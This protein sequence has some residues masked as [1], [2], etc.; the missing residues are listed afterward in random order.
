LTAPLFKHL[1]EA[2][3]RGNSNL[4]QLLNAVWGLIQQDNSVQPQQ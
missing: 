4:T 1:I 3:A 2:F